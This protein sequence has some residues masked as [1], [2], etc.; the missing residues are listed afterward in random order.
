MDLARGHRTT[1][2]ALRPALGG[3]SL[4]AILLLPSACSSNL[5]GAAPPGPPAAKDPAVEAPRS[6]RV[7][8]PEPVAGDEQYPSNL[9]VEKDVRLTA[10]RSGVIEEVLADRG[11]RVTAG[12]PLARLETDIAA[13][14]LEMAEEDLRLAQAEFDRLRP[15]HEEKIVSAQDF[16]RAEI[17]L[18][19]ARSR[20]DLARA[21][22]ERCTIRA[23][24]DGVVV[25]RWAVVGQRV[26]EEDAVPLFRVVAR[27]NLRARVDVPEDRLG[28]LLIGS[29]A[30]VETQ[31]RGTAHP[32]RVIFISPAIDAASGTAPVIVE[33]SR[34]HGALRP[35]VS[36]GVRFPGASG[37][38][39]PALRIPREAL[40]AGTPWTDGRATVLVARGDRVVV[41]RVHVVEMNGTSL[42][43]RGELAPEDRVIVGAAP[44]L[45]EGDPVRTV[46]E[47]P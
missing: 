43:V 20:T 39:P 24:F 38:G 4:A 13:R 11:G 2:P 28:S 22:L 36:V 17:A 23:P 47:T 27:E 16:Q 26:N 32:A 29:R 19:Q 25:E 46:E 30:L 40:A 12:Q 15:L 14:E 34:A 41:R 37:G 9:Y 45:A 3:L 44:G 10:R 33:V 42:V 35:G 7:A 21:V 8:R 5:A 1:S 18:G 31:G 6:V